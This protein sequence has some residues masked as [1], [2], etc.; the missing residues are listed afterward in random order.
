[1]G[2]SLKPLRYS[3]LTKL[4]LCINSTFTYQ[5]LQTQPLPPIHVTIWAPSQLQVQ[6]QLD[7]DSVTLLV[8]EYYL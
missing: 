5:N 1:M 8:K 4:T 6:W 3:H 7:W 2:P